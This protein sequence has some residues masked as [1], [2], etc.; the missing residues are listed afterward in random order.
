M[1]G[2]VVRLRRKAGPAHHGRDLGRRRGLRPGA[3]G[4][5]APGASL[6]GRRRVR[7]PQRHGAGCRGDQ[8]QVGVQVRHRARLD[9]RP[10]QPDRQARCSNHFTSTH[11]QHAESFWKVMLQ[12]PQLEALYTEPLHLLHSQQASE[13]GSAKVLGIGH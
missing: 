6:D 11:C 4:G 8:D 3:A 12:V 13:H 9:V 2:A 1:P 5:A 7:S 10:V